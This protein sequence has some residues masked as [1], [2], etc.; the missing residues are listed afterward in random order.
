MSI[1]WKSNK[2]CCRNLLFRNW[3]VNNKILLLMIISNKSCC[4]RIPLTHSYFKWPLMWP[5]KAWLE[6]KDCSQHLHWYLNILFCFFIF[7]TFTYIILRRGGRIYIGKILEVVGVRGEGWI[8]T[9]LRFYLNF[10]CIRRDMVTILFRF[11]IWK[12]YIYYPN[13]KSFD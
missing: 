2:C 11:F 7:V 6:G 13:K 12:Y 3:W 10:E 8:W 1:A 4:W 9:Q 5:T